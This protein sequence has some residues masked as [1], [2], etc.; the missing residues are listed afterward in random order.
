M[1]VTVSS[2]LVE[3]DNLIPRV[4]DRE[5]EVFEHSDI[6][7][8]ERLVSGPEEDCKFHQF[9][10]NLF[11]YR[12][13]LQESAID[14]TEI[15]NIFVPSQAITLPTKS[16]RISGREPSK[17]LIRDQCI[18]SSLLMGAICCNLNNVKEQHLKIGF[19]TRGRELRYTIG[20]KRYAARPEG[21]AV[22]GPRAEY[23]PIIS[24]TGWFPGQTWSELLI[25]TFSA[26]LGQ[27]TKNLSILDTGFQ[28]QEVFIL[29]FHGPYI[30]IARGFFTKD[31]ISRVYA[32]GHFDQEPI[33]LQFT[34]SYDLFLK[35]DWLEATRVLTRLI[36]YLLSGTARVGA[37]QK[38]S[39]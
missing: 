5:C 26:M 24:F 1:S 2:K 21:A 22:V 39:K 33:N 6:V 23:L 12:Y 11:S 9:L 17:Y 30:H 3:L 4:V 7:D 38:Y 31:L 20:G 35:E 10:Y 18:I 28:D 37:V 25:E 34:R 19:T 16:W 8:E 32:Q 36:R 14:T 27:L 13:E 15:S 29:G